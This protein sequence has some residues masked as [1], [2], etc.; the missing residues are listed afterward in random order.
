MCDEFHT[1]ASRTHHRRPREVALG[2]LPP[3]PSHTQVEDHLIATTS[4]YHHDL[5]LE[6]VNRV[7]RPYSRP[8]VTEDSIRKRV[9]T[10]SKERLA[11]AK[12]LRDILD[13]VSR[14]A[15][16]PVDLRSNRRRSKRPEREW[17]AGA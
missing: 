14:A 4:S 2:P 9:T 11:P 17:E 13:S 1:R 10:R 7:S 8:E 5:V 12:V 6:L 3:I 16:L 15:K